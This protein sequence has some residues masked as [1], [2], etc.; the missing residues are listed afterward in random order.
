[1]H[2]TSTPLNQHLYVRLGQCNILVIISFFC[3]CECFQFVKTK[4]CSQFL[5]CD[6][7]AVVLPSH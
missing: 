2:I 6:V 3:N 7:C 1:M 4:F 5:Y